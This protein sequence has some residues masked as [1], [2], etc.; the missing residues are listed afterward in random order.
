MSKKLYITLTLSILF[1]LIANTT[2]ATEK[3]IAS[4]PWSDATE[5]EEL[6]AYTAWLPYFIVGDNAMLNPENNDN[7]WNLSIPIARYYGLQ[8][9]NIVDERNNIA[10]STNAALK[11]ISQLTRHFHNHET[12]LYAMLQGAASLNDLANIN[13]ININDINDS[14]V[15]HLALCHH[16]YRNSQSLVNKSSY[17]TISPL[18]DTLYNHIGITRITLESPVRTRSIIDSLDISTSQWQRYNRHITAADSVWLT[19]GITLF[20]PNTIDSIESRIIAL[21]ASEQAD[22][23][24]IIAEQEAKRKAEEEARRKAAEEAAKTQIYT[25]KS[26]DTLGAIAIRY[27][28]TVKQIKKW[29]NLRSD[30]IRIGQKLQIRPQ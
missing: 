9:N 27:H 22:H 29:N 19:K 12:A 7:I 26:G 16:G 25:V 4:L 13:G 14:I 2:M 6:P 11:Y 28:V 30:M 15:A 24:R 20:F 21:Y 10:L 8:I 23:E 17:Y 18:F 5:K 3:Q 1:L